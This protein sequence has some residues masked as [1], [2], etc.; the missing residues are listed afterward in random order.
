MIKRTPTFNNTAVHKHTLC[1]LMLFIHVFVLK[2]FENKTN[3]IE[4]YLFTFIN[5]IYCRVII[6]SEKINLIVIASNWQ[7]YECIWKYLVTFQSNWHQPW[8]RSNFATFYMSYKICWVDYFVYLINDSYSPR[9]LFLNGFNNWDG[10]YRKTKTGENV[11]NRKFNVLWFDTEVISLNI[12]VFLY[13]HE[14]VEYLWNIFKK[15]CLISKITSVSNY[16]KIHTI[17]ISSISDMP[18]RQ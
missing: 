1:I 16:E 4:M 3:L 6:T 8:N 7:N 13:F 9:N 15:N 5:V 2:M 18:W 11:I 12:Q 10:Y 17:K 14:C